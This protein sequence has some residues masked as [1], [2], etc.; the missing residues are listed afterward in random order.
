[1][2]I[3]Y[4]VAE[5]WDMTDVIFIFH[6]G[7][8]LPFYA[9]TAQK[10]IIKKKKENLPGD[11]IILLKCT[12]NYDQIMYSSWDMVYNRW[13]DKW[14]DRLMDEVKK[15]HI[16]VGAPHKNLKNLMTDLFKENKTASNCI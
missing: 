10:I 2:I 9:P 6:F 13:T 3:C 5:I 15:W 1:M 7:L 4:T 12:K 11:I 16:E 8:V 14:T